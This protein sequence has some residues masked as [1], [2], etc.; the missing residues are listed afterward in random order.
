[1]PK[2]VYKR[3][4][5]HNA[6]MSETMKNSKAAKAKAD[7]QIGIPRSPETCA[8]ISKAKKGV[9]NSPETCAAMSRAHL[10]VPLSPEHCDAMSA[11]LMGH[12]VSDEARAAVSRAHTGVPLSPEHCAAIAKA[13]RNSESVKDNV[14]RMCGGNDICDHH[15]IYD[16][17]DLSLNTVQMT[18]KDHQKLHRLLQKLG[19]I[20]PHINVKEKSI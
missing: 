7:A 3:K 2:G 17:N 16:H 9:L 14:D 4:P 20:V 19:Y 11:A 18:R 1:M 6:A 10:G 12:P 5:E 13:N 8:K 15:Y